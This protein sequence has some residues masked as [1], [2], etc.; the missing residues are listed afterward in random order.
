M[1]DERT[2]AGRPFARPFPAAREERGHLTGEELTAYQAGELPPGE[3]EA[4]QDHLAICR[5][6]T[7]ALS[8]IPRFYELME[9]AELPAVFDDAGTA[10]VPTAAETAAAW[11]A[12]S[13][14]LPRAP[15]RSGAVPAGRFRRVATSPATVAA[16]AAG[17]A[18][19]LLGF[20]LWIAF[21]R[22]AAAPLALALP[23]GAE[24]LRGEGDGAP[25]TLRVD[26]GAVVALPLPPGWPFPLYRIE[27]RAP[28]GELRLAAESAPTAVA[29]PSA[30]AAPPAPA[31]APLPR[32][33]TVAIPPGL[34]S[35][36]DYRLRI[37]GRRGSHGEALAEHPLHALA[38]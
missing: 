19:C 1:S 8:E 5:E 36:G 14:R 31:S 4:V 26:R 9:A 37:V 6:C 24:V 27:I 25:V 15:A 18:A 3:V 13:A 17:L 22:T 33:V 35:P 30:G 7:R 21:H 2:P 32:L 12:L 10:G 29:T 11:Q 28:G 16:L 34:L 20:P 38:P 23:G